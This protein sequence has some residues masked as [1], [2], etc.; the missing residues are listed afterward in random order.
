MRI[1][2][3]G[4]TGMLGHK[5]FINFLRKSNYVIR[6]SSR[7]IPKI[8]IK[9]KKYIDKNLDANNILD[10]KK[11]IKEFKPNLV[12]N[13]IGVIKQKNL[14]SENIFFYTN[15]VFPHELN[16]FSLRCKTHCKKHKKHCSQ[17]IL[18]FPKLNL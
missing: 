9:Y 3:L 4:C 15:S 2:V 6:G 17:L 11:K 8:L 16:K 5:L 12:I 13:C 18:H 10:I 7:K 1:Y 14:C